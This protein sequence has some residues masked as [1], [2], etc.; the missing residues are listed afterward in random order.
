ME[1]DFEPWGALWQRVGRRGK[2]EK[3]PAVNVT[4]A[5]DERGRGICCRGVSV[6]LVSC[7][8]LLALGAHRWDRQGI[9]GKATR[10]GFDCV[11]TNSFQLTF[12]FFFF[13]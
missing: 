1:G 7:R 3:V 10:M 2:A 11:E 6:V 9:Q 8:G 5:G 4:G 13:C 12:F